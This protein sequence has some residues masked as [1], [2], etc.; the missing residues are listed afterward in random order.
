[1]TKTLGAVATALA[2]WM[3]APAALA[4]TIKVGLVGE[5]SGP[6]ADYGKE[7]MAGIKAY[8]KIHGDTVGGHKIEIVTKDT[9]GPSPEIA[10]RVAQELIVQDKVQFLAGFGL[11][12]N[13]MAVAPI[14]TQ[15][16]TPMVVMNAATAA[17]TTASPYIV[18]FSFTLPQMTVPMATW[19]SKNGVKSVYT[20]ASDYG[21]GIDA[22]E[23]FI[24]AFKA[25]GGTIVGSVRVPLKSPEFAPFVQRVKDAKPQAV[26]VFLPAGEQGIAFMKSF[27]ERGLAQ[28]GIKV[29]APGD[30]TDDNV[31]DAMGDPILGVITTHNY[32]AAHDSPENKAFLKAFADANGTSM[33]PNFMAVAAYDGMAAIYETVRKL[34]GKIDGEKAMDVLK[35]FKTTS[36]RGAVAIDPATREIVETVYVR[37]VERRD[38]KLYNVEFD[39][40]PNVKD[41]TKE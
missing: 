20:V 30:L 10:K 4:D 8:Q 33:R 36:P 11:T 23:T 12:P 21:P 25:N 16:K 15:S 24:K 17:I 32:S 26:F 1:M 2:A 39:S 3:T 37:R 41:P 31:L 14:A 40:F 18:R 5:F 27:N 13:A 38:G 6:F 19:A 29:I 28:A 35:N 9:T 22:E 7:M 34:N